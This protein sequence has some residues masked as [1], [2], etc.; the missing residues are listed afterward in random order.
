MISCAFALNASVEPFSGFA[1]NASPSATFA[2]NAATLLGVKSSL[3]T[4]FA[5]ATAAFNAS[6]AALGFTVISNV[7]VAAFCAASV[8]VIVTVDVP[9]AVGVPVICLV[10]GSKVKPAGKPATV[11]V[12]AT[13][14]LSS[15][16]NVIGAIG[17]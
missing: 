7:D 15:A 3:A 11:N 5:S 6:S 9:S 10:A 16:L 8:A 12:G 13:L 17:V 2:S 14:E 1:S 4:V